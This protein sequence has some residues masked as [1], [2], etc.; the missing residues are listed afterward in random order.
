M[1]YL[2]LDFNKLKRIL[3]YVR[4]GMEYPKIAKKFGLTREDLK[5]VLKT[6]CEHYKCTILKN[7][8]D[9]TRIFA[10]E[11]QNEQQVKGNDEGN[12]EEKNITQKEEQEKT[13]NQKK[14]VQQ[15]HKLPV[16]EL[17][18]SKTFD[19]S[20]FTLEN[21]IKIK[22]WCYKN[23]RLPSGSKTNIDDSIEPEELELYLLLD[24]IKKIITRKYEGNMYFESKGFKEDMKIFEVIVEIEN[25]FNVKS[26]YRMYKNAVILRKWC[27]E[28][29][30]KP[31]DKEQ[32][33]I[34]C[35]EDEIE[36]KMFNLLKKLRKDYNSQEIPKEKKFY[37]KY[38]LEETNSRNSKTDEEFISYLKKQLKTEEINLSPIQIEILKGMSNGISMN[39]LFRTTGLEI[40]SIYNF[41]NEFCRKYNCK[42]VN[43][44]KAKK[45]Q[46]EIVLNEVETNLDER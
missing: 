23:N 8:K 33:D 37:F 6:F 36:L 11:K 31:E 43:L 14:E 25:K 41:L 35:T 5:D 39:R 20:D 24:F 17:P 19:V 21:I 12:N 38:V 4:A 27:E 42:I 26:K 2:D 18:T 22:Q 34:T 7:E 3:N 15:E 10:F 32:K 9:G 1:E 13:I 44:V 29:G 28:T 46:K 30:Y 40:S 16:L 45:G